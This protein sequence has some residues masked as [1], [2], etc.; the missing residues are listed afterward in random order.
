MPDYVHIFFNRHRKTKTVLR[1]YSR[2]RL[3]TPST[4]TT[5]QTATMLWTVL[6]VTT[7]VKR[8]T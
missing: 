5:R 1:R 7:S 8:D 3:V 4:K 6:A 2:A